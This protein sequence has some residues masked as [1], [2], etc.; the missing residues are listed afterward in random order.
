MIRIHLCIEIFTRYSYGFVSAN[1]FSNII[2][3]TL[4]INIVYKNKNCGDLKLIDS[5]LMYD[6]D[7]IFKLKQTNK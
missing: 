1:A 7:I 6:E 4:L 5:D 2:T 3:A